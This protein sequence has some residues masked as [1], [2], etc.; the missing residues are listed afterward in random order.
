MKSFES[1]AQNAYEAFCERLGPVSSPITRLPWQQL[2]E[3][4]RQA[5]IAAAQKMAEEI[6]QVH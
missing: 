3:G 5:W 2:A 4:T 1:I 6:N